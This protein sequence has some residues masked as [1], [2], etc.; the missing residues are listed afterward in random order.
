M[1]I[2]HQTT[3]SDDIFFPG[4][5]YKSSELTECKKGF[6]KN[7]NCCPPKSL[8]NDSQLRYFEK[9]QGG[10]PQNPVISEAKWGPYEWPTYTYMNNWGSNLPYF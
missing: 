4:I 6:R 8:S 2:H 5:L 10:S 9:V 1:V 7:R 3:I